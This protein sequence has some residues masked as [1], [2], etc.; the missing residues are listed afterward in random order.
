MERATFCKR[1]ART[2][3][4]VLSMLPWV[5]VIGCR[6]T[7]LPGMLPGMLPGI[8]PEPSTLEQVVTAMSQEEWEEADRLLTTI[9]PPLS[10]DE[11]DERDHPVA[12]RRR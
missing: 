10:R 7:S 11:S 9:L 4:L 5:V 2:S 8:S 6:S 3:R 1:M 12:L